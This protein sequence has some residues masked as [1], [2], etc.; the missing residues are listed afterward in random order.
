MGAE[1]EI[2][3]NGG[4]DT[5]LKLKQG[6]GTKEQEQGNKD[7]EPGV[8]EPDQVIH[9]QVKEVEQE[10]EDEQELASAWAVL[11]PEANSP[12]QLYRV[13]GAGRGLRATR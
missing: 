9:I 7:E 3:T 4:E 1:R 6:Q 11:H 10:K 13:E 8:K 2:E 12:L 5:C